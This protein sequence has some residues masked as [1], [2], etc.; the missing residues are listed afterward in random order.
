MAQIFHRS[1]NTISRASIFGAVF[2]L[3]PRGLDLLRPR[4]LALH[5]AAERRAR[6]AGPVQ[7]RAP[8]R[9][10]RDR[11]PLLPHLGREG[12]LR[13]DSA[14]EDVH[15][16]PLADLGAEPVPRAG[17]RELPDRT[18]R[19]S[20]RACTTCPTSSTSTTRIH[21]NKGVG[22]ET[23]HGRV[24]EMPLMWQAALAPDGVVPG[25]PPQSGEVPPAAGG[26]LHDGLG[27]AGRTGQAALG[28]ALVAKYRIRSR[29]VL[30]EL[31]DVP[32]MNETCDL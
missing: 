10:H 16:L 19:S 18:G 23:C 20:G 11:L 15:E 29:A 21:V 1:T 4:S 31:L 3:G 14:D 13:R 8:R 7:P 22:C 17:A 6:A 30:D 9:R 32:P 27:A 12:R 5:D 28:T 2:L 26:G 24:D 25:V